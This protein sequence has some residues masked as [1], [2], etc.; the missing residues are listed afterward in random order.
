M[1]TIF[2]NIQNLQSG[3]QGL[4]QKIDPNHASFG[5]AKVDEMNVKIAQLKATNRRISIAASV[6]STLAVAMGI[7]AAVR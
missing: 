7:G 4:A 5:D 2:L 3:L 6:L 1:K